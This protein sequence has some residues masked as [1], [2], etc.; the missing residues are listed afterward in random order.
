MSIMTLEID[1]SSTLLDLD[2][3]TTLSSAAFLGEGPEMSV[4]TMLICPT[5]DLCCAS[6]RHHSGCN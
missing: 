6:A 1:E 3:E 2:F 4:S 5:G